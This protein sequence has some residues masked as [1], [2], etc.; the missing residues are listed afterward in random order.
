VPAATGVLVLELDYREASE[1][2]RP[3]LSVDA[4]SSLGKFPQIVEPWAEG[5][6]IEP[7]V[8]KVSIGTVYAGAGLQTEP[9]ETFY[10]VEP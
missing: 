4:G 10:R 7:V 1:D 3:Y 8:S 6:P 5:K 2:P 9:F